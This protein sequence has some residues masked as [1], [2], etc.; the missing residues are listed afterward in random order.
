MC[1]YTT[2]CKSIAQMSHFLTAETL[3]REASRPKIVVWERHNNVLACQRAVVR[4]RWLQLSLARCQR[5]QLARPLPSRCSWPKI[6]VKSAGAM[7]L[8]A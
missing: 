1:C 4:V 7:R 3:T 2:N 5:S 6:T 8:R